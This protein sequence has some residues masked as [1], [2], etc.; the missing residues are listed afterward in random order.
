VTEAGR[1]ANGTPYYQRSD[2]KS[3]NPTVYVG[4]D[5]GHG[6]ICNRIDKVNVN[7]SDPAR[8]ATAN[9]VERGVAGQQ[10]F[11]QDAGLLAQ[12]SRGGVGGTGGTG[13]KPGA[14]GNTGGS[15]NNSGNTGGGDGNN[16]ANGG[17]AT[18]A[19]DEQLAD[20]RARGDRS[21][22]N[23]EATKEADNT[24]ECSRSVG[25]SGDYGCGGTRTLIEGAKVTNAVTQAAGSVATA[26][27][28]QNGQQKAMAEGTQSAALQAA[29]D[30][31][32]TSGQIQVGTGAINTLLG[33]YQLTKSFGHKSNANEIKRASS[34]DSINVVGYNKKDGTLDRAQDNHKGKGTSENQ[35]GYLTSGNEK[36]R[37]AIEAFNL[38]GEISPTLAVNAPKG[39]AD[40]EK[41][42]AARSGA[43]D[44]KYHEAKSI[45]GS[46][47][48]GAQAEQ[49]N[50]A[51]EALASGMLS[52]TTGATQLISGG[53]NLAGA[54]ELEK[55]A[56]NLKQAENT[57]GP[58]TGFQP[59]GPGNVGPADALA[60][61]TPDSITPSNL[62]AQ[63][64]ASEDEAKEPPVG[65]LGDPTGKLADNNL[66]DAG[67]QAGKFNSKDPS[68]GGGAGGGG[69]GLG[70]GGGTSAAPKE[71]EEAAAK[72]A[73]SARG[74]GYEGGGGYAATGGGGGGGADK[75]PDLSG[76]LAQFLP[77]DKEDT[78]NPNGILD[79]GGRSP[80]S[81]GPI[82][83]LD[84]NTN[85][86]ERI[87]DTYQDKNRR[88]NIGI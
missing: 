23:G 26:V 88:G 9:D 24:D 52:I 44:A 60:P 71:P 45:L 66:K 68:A 6:G 74:S 73:D 34:A 22:R 84:R 13:D 7:S 64:E 20:A 15:T 33:A 8:P 85:I 11:K 4:Q 75:G 59:L 54:N 12:Y 65:G 40:Y 32:R 48:R 16:E 46:V 27:A 79:F 25:F 82:S 69:A 41:Q 17:A 57:V 49:K 19:T 28:G 78:K 5:C 63:A 14:S 38:Q 53:F 43:V 83:L 35:S 80:A 3:S 31:Q 76:L 37:N 47:G 58:T 67:P 10:G 56:R 70:G 62:Q 39:T 61:R 81:D 87:H 51:N 50:I 72:M 18:N 30:T 1:F 36:T 2:D 55:A 86:F 42:L 77:K 21:Y 29:A